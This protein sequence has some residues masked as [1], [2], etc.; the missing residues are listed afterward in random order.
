MAGFSFNNSTDKR[1]LNLLQAGNLLI[2]DFG[3]F[4]VAERITVIKFG[5][6]DGGGN[7]ASCGG[8]KLRTYIPQRSCL[9]W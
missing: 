5:V 3:R 4:Y 2:C 9:I 1:V 7:G 8:I 6:N